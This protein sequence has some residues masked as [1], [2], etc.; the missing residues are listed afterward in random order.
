[1][2]LNE[3]EPES[4]FEVLIFG[5]FFKGLIGRCEENVLVSER[6]RNPIP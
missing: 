3:R 1:M 2:R 6:R 4:L 5:R